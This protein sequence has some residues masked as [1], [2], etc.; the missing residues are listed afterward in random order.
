MM[1]TTSKAWQIVPKDS[2]FVV[3]NVLT[4]RCMSVANH[5]GKLLAFCETAKDEKVIA[6]LLNRYIPSCSAVAT[7]S[8]LISKRLL[9]FD[10]D[11]V[12]TDTIP[13]HPTLWGSTHKVSSRTRIAI[14]GVPFGLG[15]TVDIRCKDFPK[16]LRSNIWSYYSFRKLSDN[17]LNLNPSVFG[18]CINLPKFKDIV[19][20]N[21]IADLG[22]VMYYCGETSDM[23]YD[24]LEKISLRI[25]RE[26]L[27]PIYIGGDHS[28]TYPIVAALNEEN[29]QFAVLHFD[30]HTDM[31]D[32]VIMKLH[33]QF[34][35]KL[36]N[37]ANVIKRILDFDNVA[38]VYQ[39]GVREPFLYDDKKITRIG[40]CD[41]YE[42][43]WQT[44]FA[45]LKMPVYLTFDVDFFD[46]LLA[47]G[48][49]NLLPEGGDYENTLKFLAQVLIHK[50]V[51]GVD[52]V[53][54]NPALDIRN[55]TTLLV[56]SLLMHIISLL[57]L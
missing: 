23:F 29:R 39:I 21:S 44:V 14:V 31:K 42:S 2:G 46:P 38:H 6:E 50:R 34:G 8:A 3:T 32:G 48:T 19:R 43:K 11:D 54:A 26:G 25:I 53:E 27:T 49:A 1:L 51:L 18:P 15:N 45:E 52:I 12:F 22:D 13:A 37:H 30:A 20:S 10:G 41:I 57:E 24:R 55:K 40:I 47:P 33:E 36:V 16:H 17:L 5:V 56:N 9:L 35:Q 7:I 28:I 4:G